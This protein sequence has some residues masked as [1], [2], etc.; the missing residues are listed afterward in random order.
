M[1]FPQNGSLNVSQ[2]A[3][4]ALAAALLLDALLV[5]SPQFCPALTKYTQSNSSSW[6]TMVSVAAIS[7]NGKVDMFCVPPKTL[8]FRQILIAQSLFFSHPIL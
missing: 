1:T 3:W 5:Q 8:A 6:T 2:A 7:F 4:Q